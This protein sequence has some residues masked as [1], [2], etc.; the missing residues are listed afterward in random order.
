[1]ESSEQSHSVSSGIVPD[2]QDLERDVQLTSTGLPSTL[3]E[4]TRKSTPLPESTTKN[5]PHPE[6]SLKDK[7]SGGNIPPADM[8]PIHTSV[9]D[10][11]GTAAKYQTFADIQAY[12]LSNDELDKENDKEEVLTAGDDMDEDTQ[13]TDEVRTSSP[14]QDQPEPSHVQESA[15]NSSNH[16]L[17][18]FDN[19]FPLT[20]RQ[21]IK[22]LK[23]VSR[24]LFNRIAEF[25]PTHDQ[26]ITSIISHPESSQVT[27][28]I[29]KGKGIATELDED[30]SKRLLPAS[31]IIRPDPNE[32]VRD[33][34]EKMK[35]ATEEA[36]LL[37]MSRPEVI[38][39]VCEEAKKLGIDPKEAISTKAEL[40]KRRVEEYMWTMTNRIKPEP[41]IDVRI[42]PNTKPI[43]AFVFRNNDKR[44]FDIHNPFKFTDFGSTKLDE[45]GPIIQK[46]K[47][48]V[49]KY[50][51]TSLSK[52][53]ERLKKI[54]EEHGIQSALPT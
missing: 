36:K 22:Y 20:K 25:Q 34:E 12:L 43:V 53:Y 47:N 48:F 13:A 33:K 39:V 28:R 21:L 42:H 31:T 16:D 29:D 19:K 45:L 17:K 37:A 8:E 44:N 35:K 24:V 40:N 49:I 38:K 27:P 51:M 15:S 41:I 7:D 30:P 54:P 5:T 14:T 2:P 23:K 4:G 6:G 10:P 32:P 46:K 50:L 11:S 1:M 52:R 3:D 9:A 18:R 26:Q